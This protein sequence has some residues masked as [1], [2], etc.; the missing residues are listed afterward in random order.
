M[1]WY[2][3]IWFLAALFIAISIIATMWELPELIVKIS[4]TMIFVCLI[5]GGY[6]IIKNIYKELDE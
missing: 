2:E 5:I 4:A 1:K 6:F 3:F